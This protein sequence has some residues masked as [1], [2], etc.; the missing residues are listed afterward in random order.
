MKKTNSALGLLATLSLFFT[1]CMKND[2]FTAPKP[3]VD[4]VKL[5]AYVA[6]STGF[7][8]S[9][10]D[11]DKETQSFIVNDDIFITVHDAANRMAAAQ[12]PQTEQWRGNYLVSR[13]HITNVDYFFESSVNSSWKAA[14]RKAIQNWNAVNGTILY[15]REVTTKSAANVVVNTSYS[16]EN[17]VARAYLPWSDGRPGHQLTINTKYNTLSDAYKIFTITHEMGH[18]IGLLHTDQRSGI[19][20]T[21]T[22]TTDSKS[23]MNSFILPWNGFTAGDIKAVQVLYK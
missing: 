11:F 16:S 3:S 8:V 2:D 6:S 14:S 23:V 1:S 13:T 17:W 4:V 10:V 20:I 12:G 9:K 22:P 7:D 19:F 21:G 18:N 5:S 15:M